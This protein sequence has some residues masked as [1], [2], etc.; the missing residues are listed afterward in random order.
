M[1]NEVGREVLDHV[2][3]RERIR[4][5]IEQAMATHVAPLRDRMKQ[6]DKLISSKLFDAASGQG[7][8]QFD[9]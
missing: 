5:N 1:K 9:E 7:T 8:L 2:I 6:L 3:E 4:I